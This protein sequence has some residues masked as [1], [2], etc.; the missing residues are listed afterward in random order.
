[1]ST[2]PLPHEGLGGVTYFFRCAQCRALYQPAEGVDLRTGTLCVY[3]TRPPRQR[4]RRS[5]K[6]SPVVA[7]PITRD[8]VCHHR[9][10]VERWDGAAWIAVEVARHDG[11]ENGVSLVLAPHGEGDS[12]P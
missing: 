11:Q 9:G 1:M 2:L 4:Q 10:A 6:S 5:L 7:P 12:T 8:T 3:W